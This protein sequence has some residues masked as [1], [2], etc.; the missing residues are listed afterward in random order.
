MQIF[1]CNIKKIYYVC[2]IKNHKNETTMLTA[3]LD[4]PKLR[5]QVIDR[6]QR[7]DSQS[8]TKLLFI[9]DNH[10]YENFLEEDDDDVVIDLD[11]PTPQTPEEAR[12]EIE[13]IEEEIRQGKFVTLEEGMAMIDKMIKEYE[14]RLVG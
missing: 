3:E 11:F 9:I 6:V 5:S 4:T 10:Q 14:T 2:T 7:L 12:K 13:E 1:F 8:L